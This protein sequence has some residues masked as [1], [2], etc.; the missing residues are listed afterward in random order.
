MSDEV[1]FTDE[2]KDYARSLVQYHQARVDMIYDEEVLD[3]LER[4]FNIDPE[5]AQALAAEVW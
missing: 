1:E 4:R 2:M 5:V 3:P